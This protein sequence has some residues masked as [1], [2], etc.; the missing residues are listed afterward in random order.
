MGSLNLGTMSQMWKCLSAMSERK[1]S[2]RT[3]LLFKSLGSKF[4]LLRAWL[5]IVVGQY[6]FHLSVVAP[7]LDGSGKSPLS[8]LTSKNM[9]SSLLSCIASFDAY[10]LIP[11]H[12][13]DK[14][15]RNN[16]FQS[17]C[18]SIYSITLVSQPCA[19]NDNQNNLI[20]KV[21]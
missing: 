11:K 12:I 14:Y 13:A 16:L 10:S 18:N 5:L 3:S 17:C 1:K 9:E 6:I 20:I 7:Y 15:C 21:G 4:L 2:K 19:T 8:H